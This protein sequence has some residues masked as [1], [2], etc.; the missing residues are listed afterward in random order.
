M[1]RTPC[2]SRTP[3]RNRIVDRNHPAAV[4]I[5]VIAVSLEH[6]LIIPVHHFVSFFELNKDGHQTDIEDPRNEVRWRMPDKVACMTG[7]TV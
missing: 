4:I 7:R 6:T 1:T 3:S 5:D 2:L